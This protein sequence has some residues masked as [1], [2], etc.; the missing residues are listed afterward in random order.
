MGGRWI[1]CG[2]RESMRPAFFHVGVFH[3]KAGGIDCATIVHNEPKA[4]KAAS[5]HV[6][7][8]M[9]RRVQARSGILVRPLT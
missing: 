8:W 6:A 9:R 3:R 7:G 5:K 1:I 2:L 4:A